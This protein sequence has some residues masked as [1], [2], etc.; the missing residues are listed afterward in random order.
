MAGVLAKT[1]QFLQQSRLATD[2]E[3]WL[4]R[5]DKDYRP[6]KDPQYHPPTPAAEDRNL[7]FHR[8]LN[9]SPRKSVDNARST[10]P[11][12]AAPQM[13]R[14]HGEVLSGLRTRPYA[15]LKGTITD[16]VGKP[17]PCQL[18]L[19]L[20]IFILILCGVKALTTRQRRQAIALP[21]SESDAITVS[22]IDEKHLV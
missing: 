20:V 22:I 9:N 13:N 19:L 7:V 4:E 11:E 10:G 21:I 16:A 18:I 15:S 17:C 5:S 1:S 2:Y 6:A 3:R 12:S 8:V 14:S